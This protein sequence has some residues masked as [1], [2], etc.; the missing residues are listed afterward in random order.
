CPPPCGGTC[1]W[2]SRY[3]GINFVNQSSA[4]SNSGTATANTGGNT[5]VGNNSTNVASNSQ[6]AVASG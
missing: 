2:G 4:V 3:S 5:A 1:H 6:T